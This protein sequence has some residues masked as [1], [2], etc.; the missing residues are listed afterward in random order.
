[1]VLNT[2][3]DVHQGWF[4]LGA[5]IPRAAGSA[6]RAIRRFDFKRRYSAAGATAFLT[7]DEPQGSLATNSLRNH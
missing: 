5:T 1:M 6:K 4:F 3:R 7:G 2:R